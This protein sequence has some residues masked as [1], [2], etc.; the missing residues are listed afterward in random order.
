MVTVLISGNREGTNKQYF[1][2]LLKRELIDIVNRKI[3]TDETVSEILDVFNRELSQ[4]L[5]KRTV[6]VKDVIDD[7][8][9]PNNLDE[10][11]GYK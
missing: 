10:G 6:Y 4:I 3:S 5:S 11:T 7:T 2:N 9:G 1:N 8:P